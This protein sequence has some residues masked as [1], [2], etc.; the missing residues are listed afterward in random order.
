MTHTHTHTHTHTLSL[1]LSLSLSER[2]TNKQT[3]FL[4]NSNGF[5]I[6]LTFLFLLTHKGAGIEMQN[7]QKGGGEEGE[8]P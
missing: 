4:I 1:S 7:K 6:I 8:V 3:T 2:Y 5:T